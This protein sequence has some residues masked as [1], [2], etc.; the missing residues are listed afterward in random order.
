MQNKRCLE[1]M[2]R[3]KEPSPLKP[4]SERDAYV[5]EIFA[6]AFVEDSQLAPK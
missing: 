5:A 4:I 2:R 3:I 1:I 6:R